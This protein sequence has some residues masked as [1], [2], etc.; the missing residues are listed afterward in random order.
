[1]K[2]YI[3]ASLLSIWVT[4]VLAQQPIAD[5]Q[6][7]YLLGGDPGLYCTFYPINITGPV[8]GFSGKTLREIVDWQ[9]YVGDS[10]GEGATDD[11]N[12]NIPFDTTSPNQVVDGAIYGIPVTISNFTF[13]GLGWFRP[14]KTGW[15]T[16]NIQT[17][18]AAELYIANDTRMNCVE[19][20]VNSMQLQFKV[21]SIPSQPLEENPTGSVYL[22]AGFPYEIE[23]SYLHMQGSP[24]LNISMIDPDGDF[25][26]DISYLIQ[27]LNL[28]GPGDQVFYYDLFN[29]TTTIGW[30]GNSTAF[31]GYSSTA[32]DNYTDFTATTFYIYGTPTPH[33]TSTSETTSS[34]QIV[35]TSEVSLSSLE[36][37]ASGVQA[38]ISSNPITAISSSVNISSTFVSVSIN[39]TTKI[40]SST[41]L[42]TSSSI[43]F[44]GPA[45][46]SSVVTPVSSFPKVSSSLSVI[47]ISSSKPIETSGT[48]LELDSISSGYSKPSV[49]ADY[50]NSSLP[51][52]LGP[53]TTSS[54]V[55]SDASSTSIS[56]ESINGEISSMDNELSTSYYTTTMVITDVVTTVCPETV[57]VGTGNSKSIDYF[58]STYTTTNT[59]TTTV[60]D[61]PKCTNGNKPDMA[62]AGESYNG[63]NNSGSNINIPEAQN[64]AANSGIETESKSTMVLYSTVVSVNSNRSGGA[65]V[66]QIVT[67]NGVSPAHATA[68]VQVKPNSG[69]KFS[70]AYLMY[71]FSVCASFVLFL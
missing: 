68:A 32:N 17:D 33:I 40:L 13:E 4:S 28:Y 24:F 45:I 14:E 35:S 62:V 39:S 26:P 22:Y 55:I 66:P 21:A 12:F 15:H 61:C 56:M 29:V 6:K 11:L 50:A 44:V 64:G 10:V 41:N 38:S 53:I 18:T 5:C 27:Q 7:S 51:A 57:L 23:L 49:R 59:V 65:F 30:S 37:S 46:I 20:P 9:Y 63:S 3:L 67:T 47:L 19:N 36:I 60:I 43:I 34:S 48:N 8:P 69:T 31:L 16:F 1:M 52:S 71:V 2:L 25:H 42:V 54:V 58:T 70:S